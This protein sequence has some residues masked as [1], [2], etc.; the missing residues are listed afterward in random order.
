MKLLNWGV[1]WHTVL[2]FLAAF[3]SQLGALTSVAA[4]TAAWISAIPAALSFAVLTV[5]AGNPE[6]TVGNAGATK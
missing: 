5:A 1:I 3:F 2:V 4:T 6:P